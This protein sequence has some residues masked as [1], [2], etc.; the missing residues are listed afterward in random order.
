MYIRQ[1]QTI[2]ATQ[3]SLSLTV[4][5]KT[6]WT[7][8]TYGLGAVVRAELHTVAPTEGPQAGTDFQITATATCSSEVRYKRVGVFRLSSRVEQISN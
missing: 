6:F 2:C 7:F 1:K 4:F 5:F 3:V 8:Y